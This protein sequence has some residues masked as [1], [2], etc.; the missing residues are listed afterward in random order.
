LALDT[1]F[2]QEML[3]NGK[4]GW[5]FQ[6]NPESIRVIVEQAENSPVQLE[7]L[8]STARTG[9]TQKYNWDHV[10]DQYL[11]VLTALA[12]KK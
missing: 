2:N 1:P 8:R 3:Q 9:L 12:K 10:T 7:E 11:E 5:Y 6:K 4:H